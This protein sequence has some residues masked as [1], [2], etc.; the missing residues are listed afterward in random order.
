MDTSSN[1]AQ[2]QLYTVSVSRWTLVLL[3][4]GGLLVSQIF[5]FL[6]GLLFATT[7]LS[8]FLFPNT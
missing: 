4:S 6:G 1:L 3:S 7:T 2:P 5:L 8:D